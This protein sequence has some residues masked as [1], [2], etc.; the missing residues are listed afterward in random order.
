MRTPFIFALLVALLHHSANTLKSSGPMERE[1]FTK[2]E[3]QVSKVD[4][5]CQQHP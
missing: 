4:C 1:R 2:R 3:N 5:E